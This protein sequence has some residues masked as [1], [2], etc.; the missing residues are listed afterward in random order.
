MTLLRDPE[1]V[2]IPAREAR[3]VS[4]R[5][6]DRLVIT[7]VCGGQVG[8]VFAYNAYDISEHH[9]AAHTR[10]H[11]GRLFPALLGRFVTNRRR[12][13]LTYLADSSPGIHDMLIAACDPERY[14]ALGDPVHASCADNLRR[15]MAERGH[16]ALPFIPQPINIFMR[17]PVSDI[18]DLP[19]LDA[20]TA[21]GDTI[22][23]R[24]EMDC[25]VVVSACPQ[26]HTVIN[27][28]GPTPLAMTTYRH[29]T[30]ETAADAHH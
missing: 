19:W 26:D 30:E 23:F 12:P 15:A 24:A 7:D 11:N 28:A 2:T 17:V 4:L 9:S 10:T 14:A 16:E 5:A 25:I 21:P 1:P 20:P 13:I 22:T 3:S 8:D 18:G 27:G 6:G 29:T